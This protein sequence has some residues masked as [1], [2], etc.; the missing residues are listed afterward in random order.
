MALSGTQ[1][2]GLIRELK[3]VRGSKDN[4]EPVLT[5]FKHNAK[6]AIKALSKAGSGIAIAALYHPEI[7]DIDL[8]WGITSDDERAKGFGL[9]KMIKWHPEVMNDTA[10]FDS[11]TTQENHM[12]VSGIE[13]LKLVKELSGIRGDMAGSVSGIA[14]LKLVKRLAEIRVLLGGAVKAVEKLSR[15]DLTIALDDL[16]TNFAS[17]VM[18]MENKALDAQWAN[19]FAE[20]MVAFD[21]DP[22]SKA[23]YVAL[24][25]EL[26]RPSTAN[27]FPL[28]Y[29]NKIVAL[30]EMA[31]IMA[32]FVDES[33]GPIPTPNLPVIPV[34]ELPQGL[35]DNDDDVTT[36]EDIGE[37]EDFV[38][39]NEKPLFD[40]IMLNE[41][42]SGD[43]SLDEF[44]KDTFGDYEVP[45][46]IDELDGYRLLA[47]SET[48]FI[49]E[50]EVEAYGGTVSWGDFDASAYTGELFDSVSYGDDFVYDSVV[51]PGGIVGQIA[52]KLGMIVARVRIEENGMLTLLSGANG[53]EQVAS[54]TAVVSKIHAAVAVVFG[55]VDN[56]VKEPN[57]GL[58]AG[59]GSADKTI[60]LTGKELGDFPDTEEGKKALRN[61]AKEFLKNIRGEWFDC[62]ILGKKVEIRQRGNKETLHFSADTRKLKLIPALKQLI[63]SA[64]SSST[65]INHKLDK[66]PDVVAYYYL[67]SEAM[68]NDEM[69]SV[70]VVIE[71]DK[72]GI[73]HYD[74]MIDRELAFIPDHKSGSTSSPELDKPTLDSSLVED[75]KNINNNLIF[76]SVGSIGMV[77]N[78]F[79]EGEE[80]EVVEDDE[81]ESEGDGKKEYAIW[82]IPKGES[83]EKLLYTKATTFEEAK[84]YASV[85]EGK[86]G[87]TKT[88]IQ[89]LD[90]QE[91]PDFT[92]SI[93]PE[94]INP[95]PTITGN[96]EIDGNKSKLLGLQQ[97]QDRMKA[98][99][100]I[101]GNKKL[102]E[103]QKI[104]QLKA[105]GESEANIHKVMNPD[106]MGN[107]GYPKYA[108]TNNNAVIN[109]TKITAL[110]LM[111]SAVISAACSTPTPTT[112]RIKSA[113]FSASLT[114]FLSSDS[115]KRA[116]RD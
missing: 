111:S 27:Q 13:K 52:D 16:I 56:R 2:L 97:L 112:Q 42:E 11:T 54:P 15:R 92:N 12:Q 55:G 93:T 84:T 82:G 71:Q 63:K 35:G 60:E 5:Q 91:K 23:K 70:T 116:S 31:V 86:Y 109:N 69:L 115:R 48:A 66:K 101:V 64:K 25:K 105:M 20:K 7:G 83:D 87:A 107:I 41:F 28:M 96:S 21:G 36:V 103:A 100:K 8:H 75:S 67:D 33:A 74:L 14:K 3:Q 114:P 80:Q 32:S 77:L 1:K 106:Y 47:F 37:R 59:A 45:I 39:A 26:M 61:A 79:I 94:V 98:A 58:E 24:A 34:P 50:K 78:L 89:V 38:A 19:D 108:L 110:N 81:V 18:Y 29:S 99:N 43:Q 62:P 9:A 90:M 102:S 10:Y 85:L 40:F 22:K 104:E 46:N 4:D 95:A 68:L 57:L 65:D 44:I 6:G 72:K 88:R 49:V 76:D 53:T 113:L 17:K 51:V 73:L 30:K